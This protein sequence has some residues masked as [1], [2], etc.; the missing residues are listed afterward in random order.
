NANRFVYEPLEM[1]A[2]HWHF[3]TGKGWTDSRTASGEHDRLGG[4][5][6][7]VGMT[8]YLGQQWPASYRGRLLTLNQHGRRMNVERLEREGSGYVGRHE[9]DIL[10]AGDPW[11]RGVEVTYGPDGGVYLVDW[12]DTGECHENTGVHRNSGRIYK[13][14]YGKPAAQKVDLPHASLANL[15]RQHEQAN[16]WLARAS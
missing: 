2:D 12:S 3:D 11:F 7:H 9:P 15:V 4:G 10:F 14:T 6:A 13:V 16:E 1:H 5:H 8:I